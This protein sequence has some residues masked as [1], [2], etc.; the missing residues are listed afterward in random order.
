[1][2]NASYLIRITLLEYRRATCT[3]AGED[4]DSYVSDKYLRKTLSPHRASVNEVV[5]S[6]AY[7]ARP[8]C[9]LIRSRR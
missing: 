4:S 3:F 7:I 2:L 9:V 1:M 8:T 5:V 6:L